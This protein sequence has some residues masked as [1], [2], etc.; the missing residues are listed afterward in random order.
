MTVG[1]TKTI[2]F[3][4]CKNRKLEVNLTGGESISYAGS[5]LLSRADKMIHLAKRIAANIND[6]RYSHTF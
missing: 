2:E 5:I 6:Q 1:T 3:A 4:R